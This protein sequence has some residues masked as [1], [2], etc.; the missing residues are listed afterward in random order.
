[1]SLEC[2]VEVLEPEEVRAEMR[3]LAERIARDHA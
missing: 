1:V 2:R 3:A